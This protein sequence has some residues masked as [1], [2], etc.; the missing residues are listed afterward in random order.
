M[1]QVGLNNGT[2]KPATE[3]LAGNL[4]S[5]DFVSSEST[6]LL[7]TPTAFYDEVAIA[8]ARAIALVQDVGIN[9]QRQSSQIFEVGSRR[10]YTFSSGRVNG[11]LTLSRV[12]FAAGNLLFSVMRPIV[13]GTNEDIVEGI[14]DQGT[15]QFQAPSEDPTDIAGYGEFY[16]NLQASLFSHPIGLIMVHRD[17]GKRNRGAYFFQEAYIITHA[18]QIS[19]NQPFVLENC[20]IIYEGVFPLQHTPNAIA[21]PTPQFVDTYGTIRSGAGTA[22]P[23]G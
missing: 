4:G 6:L 3:R 1:S 2:W 20:A 12:M 18:M 14:R 22:D 23:N 17:I 13:T 16:I 9:N 19:A 7:A 11:Q 10:K 15:N 5:V 21:S 8:D